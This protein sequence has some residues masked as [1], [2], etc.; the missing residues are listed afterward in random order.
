M[1]NT[2]IIV[3][4][5]EKLVA[6]WSERNNIE[7]TLCR[8]TIYTSNIESTLYQTIIYIIYYH[9]LALCS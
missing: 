5:T 7:K 4:L 2:Q 1:H 8:T 6:Y 9:A 3:I